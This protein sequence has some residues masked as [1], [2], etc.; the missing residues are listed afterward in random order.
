MG[1]SPEQI[2]G[3]M[4]L[5]DLEQA[6]SAESR[7]WRW[8]SARRLAAPARTA[9][10]KGRTPP[11][12]W[13]PRA[14]D[15]KPDA[16]PPEAHLRSQFGHWEGDLMHFR[17]QRHPADAL[18]EALALDAG[19]ASSQQRRQPHGQRHRRGTGWAARQ[20]AAHHHLR[21]RPM[22]GSLA[23]FWTSGPVAST[24]PTR[25]SA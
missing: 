19:Q 9:Q 20:G 12:R 1:W 18:G 15:P 25:R 13:C 5:E 17:R 21:Q 24:V 6:A 14:V 2:A 23:G 8:R 22:S 4:E 16:D 11:P 3:R 10:V 7:L